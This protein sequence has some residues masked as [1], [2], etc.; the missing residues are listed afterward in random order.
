MTFK[1]RFQSILTVTI[2]AFTMTVLCAGNLFAQ[3]TLQVYDIDGLKDAINETSKA[4][5][6][7]TVNITIDGKIDMDGSVPE[8]YIPS[9]VTVNI[10]GGTLDGNSE[11]R[12]LVIQAEGEINIKETKFQ[13]CVAQGGDGGDG[14]VGG[15]GGAGL[16]GAIYVRGNGSVNLTDVG[17]KDNKATGGDGGSV[18][19]G[20]KTAGGGGGLGGDGGNGTADDGG[21]GA[22]GGGG[23]GENA[24]GG[25]AES[26]NVDGSAG[27]SRTQSDAGGGGYSN[28][29]GSQIGTGGEY[30]GGGGGAYGSSEKYAAGGGGGKNGDDATILVNKEVHGGDGGFGGGGGGSLEYGGDGGEYGGG[31]GGNN[32]GGNGGFGGGGG[33]A[34]NINKAG[35]GGYGAGDGG[36]GGGGGGLG[37]GGHLY[38]EGGV[39]VTVK[40]TDSYETASKLFDGSE[41]AGGLG[42]NNAGNGDALGAIFLNGNIIVFDGSTHANGNTIVG[43]INDISAASNFDK[44]DTTELQNHRGGVI[45][46]NGTVTLKGNNQY[47]GTTVINGGATLVANGNA[48]TDSNGKAITD[49][50]GHK[51][52][53][54]IGDLSEVQIIAGGALEIAN[55]ET[56]GFL[57]GGGNVQLNAGKTLII[58]GD[59]DPDKFGEGY[60]P[61]TGASV[62]AFAGK[63]VTDTNNA[64]T[65]HLIKTGTG[66]LTLS[67]D[68]S[69]SGDE[70]LTT[71]Y[72]GT[73]V[74]GNAKGL[75][76]GD[77]TVKNIDTGTGS[78]LRNV[79]EADPSLTSIPVVMNNFHV[80]K[81]GKNLDGVQQDFNDFVIG[82]GKDIQFG[83]AGVKGGQI[84]GGNILINM[85]SAANKVT[86]GNIG[87]Q[88]T[89]DFRVANL[90]N[91]AE[92][93]IKNGTV[94]VNQYTLSD[95]TKGDTL[96]NG[97]VRAYAMENGDEAILKA[98]ENGMTIDNNLIFDE[99]SALTLSNTAAGTNYSLTGNT[100][101]KGDMIIDLNGEITMSGVLGHKGATSIQNGKLII[102]PA[103]STTILHNLTATTNGS[104]VVNGGDLWANITSDTTYAGTILVPGGTLYKLGNG[105]WTFDRNAGGIPQDDLVVDTVNVNAGALQLNQD[106]NVNN[107][108][109]SGDGQLIVNNDMT[110]ANLTSEAYSTNVKVEDRKTLTLT[111]AGTGTNNILHNTWSG[112]TDSTVVFNSDA[113]LQNYYQEPSDWKGTMEVATG[114]TLTVKSPGGLGDADNAQVTLG[115]GSTLVIDTYQ[116]YYNQVYQNQIAQLNLKGAGTVDVVA[117]SEFITGTLTETNTTIDVTKKGLGT[118]FMLGDSTAYSKTVNLEE[119]TIYL[120]RTV[121]SSGNA[122]YDANWGTGTLNVTGNTALLVDVG[123]TKEIKEISNDIALAADKKLSVGVYDFSTAQNGAVEFSEAITGAGGMNIYGG[124]AVYSTNKTYTGDTTISNGATLQVKADTTTN[125]LV[126]NGGTL[127]FSNTPD[128]DGKDI[129]V[130]N[131]GTLTGTGTTVTGNITFESGSRLVVDSSNPTSYTATDVT[132]NDGAIA[133]IAGTSSASITRLITA[134]NHNNGMFWFTDDIQ[135]KRATGTWNNGD[136]DISFEDVNYLDNAQTR[137]ANAVANYLNAIA[138]NRVNGKAWDPN[139]LY[140]VE[141]E[142]SILLNHLENVLPPSAYDYALLEIGGQ[143]NGSIL[144]ANVQAT[145]NM[146][147]SIVTQ[148]YPHQLLLDDY[149]G[150][151][152]SGRDVFRG[153]SMRSGWTGWTNGLGMFGDTSGNNGRGTFGYDFETY[154]MSIGIEPTYAMSGNRLGFFYAYNY[155]DIDTNKTIGKGHA[156]SNFFGAYGRFVDSMGYTAFVAGFGFDDYKTNRYVTVNGASGDSRSKFDGWQGG[157]YLERGLSHMALTRFG[158]QPFVGLQYLHLSADDF[159]ETGSNPYKLLTDSSDVDSLRTNLGLRYARN[160]SRVKRGNMQMNASVSWMHEFLDADCLM[161]SKLAVSQNPS[162]FGV[163]GNSLGRDWAVLGAGVDWQ[164]RHNVSFYGS[165]D[166]Q[167]NAYQTL[168]IGN[169]G[170]RI[171][172]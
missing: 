61:A 95:G 83:Q 52:Y 54:A 154:G 145:S 13:N 69:N 31:G 48:V 102:N 57:S 19:S 156:K 172:W 72:Q 46:S 144:T 23:F 115:D 79:L 114:K 88:A 137:D 9:G 151:S 86:L 27:I 45:I 162:T 120:K 8:L 143:I 33:G 39:N 109:L 140:P 108:T 25:S 91:Y 15:G 161:T 169:V 84:T 10:I 42:G 124:T 113:T 170:T 76:G 122:S 43:D 101:G 74:L 44:T 93:R 18:I 135:G 67:G 34:S 100:S 152:S 129:T 87:F 157:F 127:D 41:V 75:G 146:F 56:I 5:N 107:V 139:H 155:T 22:G 126:K 11:H 138:D 136:L 58:A 89:N 148:L 21:F 163:L 168:H 92:T 131:G 110:L 153:Q 17:F 106:G 150:Y 64:T 51:I 59:E 134:N 96:G 159:A 70:F 133:H 1:V 111:T 20:S 123:G 118:W 77:V 62:A 149:S 37:A 65:E 142:T 94:V 99:G 14:Q 125:Y 80:V 164:W 116:P 73:I 49:G 167:V 141:D 78:K 40:Y 16:G 119:G 60:N 35:N 97:A 171:Q 50:N 55:S 7:S 82:G 24:T 3:T 104:L 71:I 47:A 63:I 121:D 117:G 28:V 32:V 160:V 38:V 26:A 158:L 103:S 66:R 4:T 6:G 36:V 85:G 2:A 105:T 90:N 130:S 98:S 53:N 165:Y 68:N 29:S 128:L 81:S 132:I 147:R 12:G 112:E 30:A 166:L